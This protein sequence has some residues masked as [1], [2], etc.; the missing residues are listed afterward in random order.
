MS[1]AKEFIKGDKNVFQSGSCQIKF[2]QNNFGRNQEGVEPADFVYLAM[3]EQSKTVKPH[4]RPCKATNRQ[5][6]VQS[7]FRYVYWDKD[8]KPVTDLYFALLKAKWIS[9]DT[10]PDSFT[11]IFEGEETDAIVRWTGSLQH[12][13]YLFKLLME[14]GY[15]Y[16]PENVPQQPWVIVQSHFVRKDRRLFA[17]WN[18]QKEPKRLAGVVTAL[19]EILNPNSDLR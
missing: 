18:K 1:E 13:W 12:L 8:S 4:K 9:E 16:I 15:I 3:D 10:D 14:K 2:I 19:A 7:T 5:K 11:S 17:D 6:I